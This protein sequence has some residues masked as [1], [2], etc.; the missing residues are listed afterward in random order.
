[1][2]DRVPPKVCSFGQIDLGE[3][4]RKRSK[5]LES[6]IGIIFFKRFGSEF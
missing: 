6:E 4:E 1:V 5:S 2:F 3:K